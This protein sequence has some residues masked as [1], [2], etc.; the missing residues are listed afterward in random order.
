MMGPDAGGGKMTH[1]HQ[2]AI[3][4]PLLVGVGAVACTIFVHALALAATVNLFRHERRL[5]RAGTGALIDLAIVA[6][7]ISF[8]FVAHLIEIALW[9]VLLVICGE[10]HEFGNAFYHSAVNYTTLGYG[11]LLLTPSWRLLGP[12]EAANGA[13]MFGVSTA[14][15]FAVIQRLLL[16]RFEDLRY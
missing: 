6:L 4:Y 7:A 2:F 9:A 12:L 8:A 16:A 10:F 5:G 14:M 15:V 3:L 1:N 11:D 13:L